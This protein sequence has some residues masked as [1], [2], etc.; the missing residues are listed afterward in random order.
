MRNECDGNGYTRS[1]VAAAL[2]R[3]IDIALQA[4]L[5]SLAN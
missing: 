3:E 4:L 2:L 5:A 1:A